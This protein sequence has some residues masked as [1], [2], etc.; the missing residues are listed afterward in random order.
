[1]KIS[2]NFDVNMNPLGFYAEGK[3]GIS[4]GRMSQG[5]FTRTAKSDARTSLCFLSPVMAGVRF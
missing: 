2:G 5:K 3:S 4:L 1:M